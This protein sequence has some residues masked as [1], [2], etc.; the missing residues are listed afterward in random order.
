MSNPKGQMNAMAKVDLDE[1]YDGKK[2]GRSMIVGRRQI[3]KFT[4]MQNDHMARGQ[5]MEYAN[6]GNN[7]IWKSNYRTISSHEDR[8]NV[9]NKL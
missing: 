5:F 7:P 4:D 1:Y 8:R 2:D 3:K 9:I 6:R